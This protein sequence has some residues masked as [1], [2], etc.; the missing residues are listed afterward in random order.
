MEWLL[1]QWH[2]LTWLWKFALAFSGSISILAVG[3]KQMLLLWKWC[4]EK[5]DRPVLNVLE[6]HAKGTV[7][8]KNS[9][10]IIALPL[11]LRQIALRCHR[12]EKSV[13]RSLHR[14]EK[15]GKVYEAPDGWCSQSKA[16]RIPKGIS[17]AF[18]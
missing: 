6:N 3:F 9:G 16:Y 2:N 18:K 14:L 8:I 7:L 12:R 15:L 4:V 11:S 10:P 1:K 13:R 5:Y 17:S